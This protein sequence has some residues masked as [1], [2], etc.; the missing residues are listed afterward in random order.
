MNENKADGT[1]TG[2][3]ATTPESGRP[4][5]KWGI[6]ATRRSTLPVGGFRLN[7]AYAVKAI[8]VCLRNAYR[9][10]GG[11]CMLVNS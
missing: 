4:W 8:A 11:R 5:G 6:A 9:D 10:C 3:R 7:L 2:L 1:R